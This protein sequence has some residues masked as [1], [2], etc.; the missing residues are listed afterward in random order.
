MEPIPHT[1]RALEAL[2]QLGR[3]GHRSTLRRLVD[4]VTA[5]VPDCVGMSLTLVD[6]DVTLTLLSSGPDVA[7]PGESR[8]PTVAR[9]AA[10]QAIRSSLSLPLEEAGR[11]VA[12]LNLYAARPN[13][14]EGHVDT[15][16]ERVGAYPARAVLD[17]DLGFESRLRALKAPERVQ[18]QAEIALACSLIAA[19]QGV[20]RAVAR[21]GL[22]SS[23]ATSGMSEVAVARNLIWLELL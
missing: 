21:D 12:G 2:E 3:T 13:A 17:A 10:E 6:D 8:W 15:I 22:R 18:E 9:P 23:A 7:P 4:D 16:A 5:V 19:T 11:V 20:D 14:F 1:A